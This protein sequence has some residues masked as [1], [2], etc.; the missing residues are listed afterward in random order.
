MGATGNLDVVQQWRLLK[1]E[2][3]IRSLLLGVVAICLAA[4]APLHA[5]EALPKDAAVRI[6]IIPFETR[7][8]SDEA[9]RA[10]DKTAGAATEIAGVLRLPFGSGPFP[11]VV[12]IEGSSG[13]GSNIDFWDRQFLSHGMATFTIDGFTGRGIVN[14]ETDQFSLGVLNMILDLYRGFGVLAKQPEIDA[15]RIAVMG[16]S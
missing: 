8:L 1:G 4:V 15:S 2:T 16:F 6:R 13:I 7:T 5:Q 10:G 9:F 11:A 12:L 3:R 14:L